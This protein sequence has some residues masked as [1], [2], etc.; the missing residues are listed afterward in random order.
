VNPRRVLVVTLA[1]IGLGLIATFPP[2][3]SLFG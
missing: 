2:V 1:L 3:W